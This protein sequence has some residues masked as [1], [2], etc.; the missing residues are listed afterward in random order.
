MESQQE[1]KKQP[2]KLQEHMDKIVLEGNNARAT[3]HKRTIECT[4]IFQEVSDWMGIIV[5]RNQTLE[6]M[7][8]RIQFL[9]EEVSFTMHPLEQQEKFDKIQQVDNEL[10]ALFEVQSIAKKEMH[11]F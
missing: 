4:K 11:E 8:E 3:L 2:W 6:D 9:K 7:S 1:A 10:N 5:R